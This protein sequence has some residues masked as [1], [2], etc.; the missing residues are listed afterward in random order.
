MPAPA[1]VVRDLRSAEDPRNLARNVES[2]VRT[3]S[4]L[5]LA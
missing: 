2:L 4:L 5:P 1:V 3:M